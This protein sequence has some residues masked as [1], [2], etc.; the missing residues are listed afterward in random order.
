MKTLLPTALVLAASLA[1]AV[2]ASAQTLGDRVASAQL[3]PAEFA[4]L[5]ADTGLSADEARGLTLSDIALIR[6]DSN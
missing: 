6:T 3:S 4:Q 2:S 5:I 1:A